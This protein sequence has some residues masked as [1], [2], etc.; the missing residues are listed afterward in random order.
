VMLR[1]E[2]VPARVVTGFAMGDWDGLLRKYRVPAS[3]SHAWVEVYFPEYGWIE[4]EP[5]AALAVFDYSTADS[6]RPAPSTGDT[7][8][9]SRVAD[10][11]LFLISLAITIGVGAALGAALLVRQRRYWNKLAP[12]RQARLLYWQM[13]RALTGS[14]SIGR[15]NV[16]PAEFIAAQAGPLSAWPRLREA[17]Q[18]LTALYIRAVYTPDEPSTHD[19]SAVRRAWQ[20]AWSDRLRRRWQSLTRR[21][22]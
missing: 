22:P 13:R 5:T 7:A 9:A 2:G 21:R 19:V 15:G 1:A 16:T 4:F 10:E 3:A 17:T 18:Q 6:P 11:Q 8:T 20:S 12:E 14:G